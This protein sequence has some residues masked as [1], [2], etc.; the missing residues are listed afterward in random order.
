MLELLSTTLLPALVIVAAL[1]DVSAYRIPNWLTGS[2]TILFFPMAFASGMPLDVF[3][4]HLVT[5]FALFFAGYAIYAAGLWG[6]GDAK[7]MTAIGLWFGPDHIMSFLFFTAICGGI[8]AIVYAIWY[9]IVMSLS[10]HSSDANLSYIQRFNKL[11]P[12]LPYGLALA[13][14]AIMAFKQ[15]WWMGIS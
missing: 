15:T 7:M 1:T 6:G 13:V 4:W 9:H 5:G 3:S 10:V 12:N 11:C 8:V 14:G 2:M